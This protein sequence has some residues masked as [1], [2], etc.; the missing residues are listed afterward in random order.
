MDVLVTISEGGS[1]DMLRELRSWLVDEPEL[2]GR[3]LLRERAVGQGD[4]GPTLEALQLLGAGGGA[5]TAASV[6]IAWLRSRSG[7]IK[8]KV[9]R[10]GET[11]EVSAKGVKGL[12]AAGVREL[13]THLAG[14]LESSAATAEGQG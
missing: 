8:I 9:T 6:I 10:N 14:Y 5:A 4:L 1:A 3:V 12:D 2:R 13:T 11:L 7:E